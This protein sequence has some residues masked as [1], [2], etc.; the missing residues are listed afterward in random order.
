MRRRPVNLSM[1]RGLGHTGELPDRTDL[2]GWRDPAAPGGTDAR[3]SRA[4]RG[5]RGR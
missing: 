4:A 2:T 3:D 1:M 5:A